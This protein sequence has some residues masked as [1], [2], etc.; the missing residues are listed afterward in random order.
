MLGAQCLDRRRRCA[1]RYWRLDSQA[2]QDG[3]S[4]FFIHPKKAWLVCR[5]ASLARLMLDKG[6]AE[7]R[8]LED[9]GRQFLALRAGTPRLMQTEMR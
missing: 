8:H 9:A 6:L 4:V 2:P 1:R 7:G 5:V 3:I